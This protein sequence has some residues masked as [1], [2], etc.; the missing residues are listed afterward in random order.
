MKQDNKVNNEPNFIFRILFGFL[1]IFIIFYISV[2]F[3][4]GLLLMHLI[5]TSKDYIQQI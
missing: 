2:P 5:Y 3:G 1:I 4:T